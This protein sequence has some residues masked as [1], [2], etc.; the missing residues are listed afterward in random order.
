MMTDVAD[1]AGGPSKTSLLARFA[2][3]TLSELRTPAFVIDESIFAKNC[4]KM[5][6]SVHDWGALFRAH[7]KTHKV[8]RW[9]SQRRPKLRF[10]LVDRRGCEASARFDSRHHLGHHSVHS[11]RGLAGDQSRFGRSRDCQR[12]EHLLC[13]PFQSLMTFSDLVWTANRP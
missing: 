12:R 11:D 9:R 13:H 10:P 8:L 1:L 2:G 5:H 4:A 3:R 6:K 7:V